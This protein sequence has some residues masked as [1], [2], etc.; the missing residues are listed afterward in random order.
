MYKILDD[1]TASSLKETFKK[2]NDYRD[3][4]N[5]RNNDVNVLLPK[6]KRDFLRKTFQ[7]NGAMLW[8]NLPI[9][10]KQAE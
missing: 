3:R 10:L 9:E 7:Y 5:L 6:P 8:N 1:Y 4:Y 2:I